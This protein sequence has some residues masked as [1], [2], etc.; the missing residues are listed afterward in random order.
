MA[1]RPGTGTD[2]PEKQQRLQK[3]RELEEQKRKQKNAKL[4]I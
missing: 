4:G 2:D 1:N 3:L